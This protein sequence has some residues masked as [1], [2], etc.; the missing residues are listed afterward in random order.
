MSKIYANLPIVQLCCDLLF[1]MKGPP[2]PAC[3]HRDAFSKGRG[4]LSQPKG[5]PYAVL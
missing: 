3:S 4:V 1:H 5:T 2:R